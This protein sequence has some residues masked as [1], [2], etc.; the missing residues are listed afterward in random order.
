MNEFPSPAE[1][2]QDSLLRRFLGKTSGYS[3]ENIDDILHLLT[4]TLAILLPDYRIRLYLEDLTLGS[5]M[6]YAATG[7][8]AEIVRVHAYPINSLDFSVSRAFQTG[9]AVEIRNV[10]EMEHPQARELVRRFSVAATCCLPLLHRGR[11]IG[12]LAIDG[13]R[14]GKLPDGKNKKTLKPYLDAITPLIDQSRR[15]HQQVLLARTLNEDRKKNAALYMMASAVRLIEPLTLASVLVPAPLADQPE[16]EGLQVLAFSSKD[17]DAERLYEKIHIV[18]LDAGASLLSRY[19][20]S[21]GTIIDESF[22][23]PHYF[24]DL[25][26][27]KLQKRYLTEEIGLKSLYV[28]PC[29]DPQSRRVICIVNYYT[30]DAYQFSPFEKGLLEAHAEMAKRVIVEIG[31]EHMEIK[32]LSE[33]NELLTEKFQGLRPFLSQVLS[34]ASKLIGADTGSIALVRERAGEKWLM[35][36]NED[37][38]LVGAKNVEWLKANIP[39]LRV[40]G[41]DL[42]AEERSLTGYAAGTGKPVILANAAEAKPKGSFY[43]VINSIIQSEIAVPVICDEEVIAVICLDSLRPNFFT[44]EHQRILLIIAG[45]IARHLSD[46]QRIEKLTSEIHRLRSDVGYKDPK[47]SSYRLGNIIGRS[48]RSM[49]VV[50]VI[51]KIVPPLFNR[52]AG[53]QSGAFREETIGLPTILISGATGSGKEFIFNNIFSRLNELFRERFPG[54]RELSVK[55]TNIAAYSGELTYSE[56]FGHKRGAFTGAHTDRRGILEEANGGVVFLDEIGDADPKTQVQLLRFL[57]N[58]GFVRLGENISRFVR[59]LLVA[60]TNRNLKQLIREGKFREDLYFRLSE[61]TIEVPS[62]NERRADI[63]DLI[64]HF[65][66]KLSQIY[67]HPQ[68]REEPAPLL[69]EEA[70]RLLASHHYTGN[71]RELRSILL[72]ALFF[73]RGGVVTGKDIETILQGGKET[74]GCQER[75]LLKEKTA[76]A[77]FRRIQDGGGNFWND[78]QEPFTAKEIPRETVI[79]VIEEARR[80]GADTMPKLAVA[81]RAC[82]PAS[83]GEAEKKRFLKFKNF[84]YKTV[85]VTGNG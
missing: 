77:V 38:T 35:V 55:K 8:Q 11:A 26:A 56:L 73:R 20:D 37:G 36:E 34:K 27:E 2:Q 45:L 85:R 62:L 75:E 54:G 24:P 25:S 18:S 42:P 65:F 14:Q 7:P 1:R 74:E 57:D 48:R 49:E 41:E 12:V 30:R 15:Y 51:E 50:E 60:A 82:D 78:I 21:S 29:F 10:E 69:S 32:V 16:R 43:R 22:L 39:P 28:V 17:Q 79:R 83:T 23:N 58:G 47:I 84:L 80:H 61:L 72:R 40:G 71:I 70:H 64:T 59:V 6:C 13:D 76:L 9:L 5:L 33:I 63:P 52:I 66:G 46:M 67:G 4:E 31:G 81:L 3:K 68:D 44:E 53:W 19:I